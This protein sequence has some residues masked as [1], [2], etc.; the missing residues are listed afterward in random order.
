MTGNKV[1]LCLEAIK[2]ETRTMGFKILLGNK[3]THC[4]EKRL[5]TSS[6]L[7][8]THVTEPVSCPPG[9]LFLSPTGR[10]LLGRSCPAR[11]T[12]PGPWHL[13]TS[14]GLRHQRNVSGGDR[15]CFWA[16]ASVS[17][18]ASSP[19]AG[20]G[21]KGLKKMGWNELGFLRRYVEESVLCTN[22]PLAHWSVSKK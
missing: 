2:W 7:N 11:A 6:K 8:P 5:G 17:L 13:G 4:W 18:L 3:A 10:L 21:L 1:G 12:L 20:L 15:N 16:K 22:C 9:S 14:M 19:S